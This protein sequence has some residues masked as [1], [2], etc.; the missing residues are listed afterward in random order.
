M[1]FECFFVIVSS[2]WPDSPRF[3][4]GAHTRLRNWI[5]CLTESRLPR[6]SLEIRT[7][8]RIPVYAGAQ[9]P[10]SSLNHFGILSWEAMYFPTSARDAETASVLK[11]LHVRWYALTAG[12]LLP[13][14]IRKRRSTASNS[15]QE[16]LTTSP[17]VPAVWVTIPMHL[18]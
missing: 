6:L 17:T 18:S 9:S 8:R 1:T 13:V 11:M 16:K 2:K 5:P 12:V 14:C 3:Y 7:R 15:K 10:F 4:H